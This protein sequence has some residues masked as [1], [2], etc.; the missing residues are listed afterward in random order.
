VCRASC[1]SPSL[2]RS[3]A[4]L[5]CS[6]AR[7]VAVSRLARTSAPDGTTLATGAGDGTVILWDLTGL[8]DLL[9]HA[10]ERACSLTGRGL[11][12]EEWARFIPGLPYQDTCS[13]T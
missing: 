8:N 7:S 13:T 12:R 6:T 3:R 11:D 1:T 4:R 5:L 9:D 10:V 2:A